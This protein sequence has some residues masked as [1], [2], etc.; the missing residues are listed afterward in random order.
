MTGILTYNGFEAD[1]SSVSFLRRYP[2]SANI[3]GG[4]FP[5]DTTSEGRLGGNALRHD[6]PLASPLVEISLPEEV[7]A[8]DFIFGCGVELGEISTQFNFLTVINGSSNTVFQVALYGLGTGI[9]IITKRYNS[10]GDPTTEFLQTE[11]SLALRE[12]H[13]IEV[14]APLRSGA[15][16]S[17]IRVNGDTLSSNLR[18]S[19]DVASGFASVDLSM[20]AVNSSYMKIDDLYIA[21]GTAFSFL[22]P[23]AQVSSMYPKLDAQKNGWLTSDGGNPDGHFQYV[24][25]AAEQTVDD[26]TTYVSSNSPGKR[27]TYTYKEPVGIRDAVLAV[28]LHSDIR[29]D[30]GSNLQVE[31]VLNDTV[32]TRITA[33]ASGSYTR[34]ITQYDTDPKTNALWSIEALDGI[35]AGLKIPGDEVPDGA[36]LYFTL[37]G[38]ETRFFT[39]DEELDLP[40]AA[41]NGQTLQ[42]LDSGGTHI[43]LLLKGG[44]TGAIPFDAGGAAAASWQPWNQEKVD[45]GAQKVFNAHFRS[46]GAYLNPPEG[47]TQSTTT[48]N[49][50]DVRIEF[51]NTVNVNGSITL[52]VI[53]NT[54]DASHY[55]IVGGLSRDVLP[56]DTFHDVPIQINSLGT[57]HVPKYAFLNLEAS[58]NLELTGQREWHLWIYPS[59]DPPALTFDITGSNAAGP[60][61]TPVNIIINQDALSQ[62]DTTIYLRFQGTVGTWV[63][64]TH[65]SYTTPQITEGNL[66]TVLAVTI[67]EQAYI[68]FPGESL[69]VYLDHERSDG[70]NESFWQFTEDWIMES[71]TSENDVIKIVGGELTY[72][73]AGEKGTHAPG[74]GNNNAQNKDNFGWIIKK[75]S[76]FGISAPVLKPDGS[77]MQLLV[78]PIYLNNNA[79]DW[80]IRESFFLEDA[81]G[82]RGRKQLFTEYIFTGSYVHPFDETEAAPYQNSRFF[83]FGP[84]NRVPGDMEMQ[85]TFQRRDTQAQAN[86]GSRNVFIPFWHN[87][88]VQASAIQWEGS[89]WSPWARDNMSPASELGIEIETDPD[90]GQEYLRFWVLIVV[91]DT[92]WVKTNSADGSEGKQTGT[93]DAGGSNTL[94]IDNSASF[95]TKRVD[96]GDVI[97]NT[98]DGSECYVISRTATQITTSPLHGGL[99]NSFVTGD[100]YEIYRNYRTTVVSVVDYGSGTGVKVTVNLLS[101]TTSL[102]VTGEDVGKLDQVYNNGGGT[103]IVGLYN[104]DFEID[105]ETVYGEPGIGTDYFYM[106]GVTTADIKPNDLLTIRHNSVQPLKDA[107]WSGN[108]IFR[109]NTAYTDA[110]NGQQSSAQILGSAKE[111]GICAWAP[112]YMTGTSRG[113]FLRGNKPDPF[114]GP[115]DASL[116]FAGRG[117]YWPKPG[118]WWEPRGNATLDTSGNPSYTITLT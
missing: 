7:S 45:G 110:Y 73:F 12:W 111:K 61:P 25:D 1:L 107:D 51:S 74:G 100:S 43:P 30:A 97:Y 5:Y 35:I 103:G 36:A 67:L 79:S 102:D 77:E 101:G 28:Q 19:P 55:T 63:R 106:K 83:T 95:I 9:G 40:V 52:D 10:L 80:Y 6:A 98:R 26:D 8:D 86:L 92:N 18:S 53:E 108:G 76:S 66:S 31:P 91:D 94:L 93:A 82:G 109:Y 85:A 42:I 22:G 49:P 4:G 32:L 70:T 24:D 59:Q 3:P 72:P 17:I 65:Y 75:Q 29:A 13:Y 39:L 23:N 84:R 64:D 78:S 69:K 41:K 34:R 54:A 71:Q 58:E 47:V 104:I 48:D 99:N 88:S 62:E 21:R 68:D 46:D 90:T 96:A 16:G 20:V 60:G 81:S 27:D 113:A 15:G 33:L 44:G 115:E 14:R 2:N 87:G 11:Y 105:H 38:G 50:W 118:A 89:W 57:W 114:Y 116:T 56:G 112:Y 37:K 117:R